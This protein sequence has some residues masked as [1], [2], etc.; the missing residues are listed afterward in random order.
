MVTILAKRSV[1]MEEMKKTEQP[2][3][4]KPKEK[5]PLW[6]MDEE[7]KA[8]WRKEMKEVAERV[9]NPLPLDILTPER[10]LEIQMLAKEAAL[11]VYNKTPRKRK[12][13][14]PAHER[15]T[16]VKSESTRQTRLGQTKLIDSL[17]KEGKN[18]KQIFDAVREKIP[19]YPADKLPK[20]IKLRQY[21]MKKK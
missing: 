3:P 7:Q 15:K 14:E 1:L 13:E 4:L 21:H 16:K 12:E 19:T 11:E 5:E 18:D 20:L 2:I 8:Q 10:K 6:P 9:K 17:L